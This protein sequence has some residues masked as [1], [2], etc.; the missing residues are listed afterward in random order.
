M[1]I[2]KYTLP[3]PLSVPIKL[4]LVCDLHNGRYEKL[5]AAIEREAPDAVCVAGDFLDRRESTERGFAFLSDA[6]KKRPIFV[7][8]G[9]HEMKSAL[10]REALAARI[11]QTGAVL[12]DNESI[13]CGELLIGGLS[14]GYA[15]EQKQG[16][17]R[18]TPPPDTAF[19]DRFSR[20]AGAK[21][22]LC[23]HPEYY[24]EY[25]AS[26]HTGYVFCGHAH[27]GQW[28]FFGRGVFAPGQGLFPRYT[29]GL[30]HSR[31]I[32]SR[33]LCQT[34]RYIPRLFNPRELVFLILAPK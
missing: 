24:D 16:R 10:S 30:Y 17:W 7:S 20:E 1:I 28:R 15:P 6:A 33:G 4:A 8:L 13:R 3:A 11:A 25:L 26:R 31:L 34:N 27:G 14:S 18:R 19:L 9:N 29:A 22:L 23:H 12:L 5:V 2:T 21:L 32:V